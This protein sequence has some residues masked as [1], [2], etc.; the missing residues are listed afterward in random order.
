MTSLID[1]QLAFNSL[2]ENRFDAIV[3]ESEM[4]MVYDGR[5]DGGD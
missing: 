3:E 4:Q 2:D 1:M 5:L